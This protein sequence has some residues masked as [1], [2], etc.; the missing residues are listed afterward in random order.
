M[1]KNKVKSKLLSKTLFVINDIYETDQL[2]VQ[3]DSMSGRISHKDEL[4]YFPFCI[5]GLCLE[6]S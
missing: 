2:M 3:C 5:W 1:N 6:P 4:E